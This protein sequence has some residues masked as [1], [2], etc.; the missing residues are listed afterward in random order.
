[1]PAPVRYEELAIPAASVTQLAALVLSSGEAEA[2]VSVT[3]ASLSNGISGSG[4]VGGCNPGGFSVVA[5][6]FHKAALLK[7]L[8]QLPA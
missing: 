8:R 1:M 3:S 4:S 5:F 2:G 6:G 7:Y